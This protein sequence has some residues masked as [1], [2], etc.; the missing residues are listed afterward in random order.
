MGEAR[1]LSIRWCPIKTPSPT[2]PARG[3]DKTAAGAGGLLPR[4]FMFTSLALEAHLAGCVLQQLPH[5]L[6]GGLQVRGGRVI[7]PATDH[8]DLLPQL[9]EACLDRAQ[10]RDDRR[11]PVEVFPLLLRLVH[12]LAACH[13]PG[14]R[15]VLDI[16]RKRGPR[17]SPRRLSGRAA[18][19]P[20]LLPQKRGLTLGTSAGTI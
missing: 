16:G 18:K 15:S 9:L 4:L 7:G 1:P 19:S 2:L 10:S 3:R 11:R 5:S 8:P 14:R 20:R 13:R 6:Q 12:E 17:T